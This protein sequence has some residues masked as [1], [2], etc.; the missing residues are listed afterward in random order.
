MER[1][2]VKSY[3]TEAQITPP[4]AALALSDVVMLIGDRGAEGQ[5]SSMPPN[6]SVPGL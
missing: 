1:R 6:V 3:L 5:Y 2:S 4:S